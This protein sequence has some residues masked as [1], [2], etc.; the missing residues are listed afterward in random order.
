MTKRS[1]FYRRRPNTET[2]RKKRWNI[3]R[4][5]GGALKRTCMVLGAIMLVWI[6][7]S[8]TI[9]TLM[10]SGA[11]KA[12]LPDE[13][14]VVLKL[15]R[16]LVEKA[17]SPTLFDLF[18]YRQPNLHDVIAK[19]DDAAQDRRVKGFVLSL[20]SG[21]LSLTQIQELRAAIERF[22][23][24][25]KFTK[26]HTPSFTDYGQGM[27]L[28]YLASAFE[29]V[30]MQ[31]VGMLGLTGISLEMPYARE[32]LDKLGA[33]PEFL[34]REEY[35]SAMENFAAS[36]M[37][38]ASRENY[39]A[40]VN[41][42]ADQ[43]VG[44]IARDRKLSKSVVKSYVDLGLL[45]G[46]EALKAK[47][48]DR[49]DYADVMIDDMDEFVTGDRDSDA[50]MYVPLEQYH[51]T[52]LRKKGQDSVAVIQAVG[53]IMPGTSRDVSGA[54]AD[55]IAA[56]LYEAAEDDSIKAVLLRVDSPGGSPS[57]SETIRRAVLNVQDEG[58]QVVVSMG[59][60]A[61]S[62][63]YWIA[64]PADAIYASPATLTG[65][66]G[67]V[68]GKVSLG[69]LW[70]KLG[71]NWQSIR[72]GDNAGMFSMNEPLDA[73]GRARMNAL[74]DQTYDQFLTRVAEGRGMT[75]EEA[76]VVAKGRAWTGAQAK[77][78][79]LVDALGGQADALDYLARELG[80]TNR[81]D[82][83]VIELP[84]RKRPLEQLIELMETQVS[85]GQWFN[86]ARARL[87]TWSGLS[88]GVQAVEP[89]GLFQ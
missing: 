41:D 62:G 10:G 50:D 59:S 60:V 54:A 13:M 31:P 56:A 61:A 85:M 18:P 76:R 78:R 69:G 20:K 81:T 5:M 3:G 7:L 9:V 14:V 29:E 28:Y 1:L 25:G 86:G 49:L 6:V 83:R 44:T 79:G 34:Q 42:Y 32:A 88:S 87:A 24:T 64:A 38:P 33:R 71:I 27:G 66:I 51:R 15:D 17:G 73:K 74:I 2:I 37:S 82:L 68:M 80:H 23:A 48:I 65:S 72:Y 16:G 8:A 26:F 12:P 19:I 22:R 63:G 55:D 40:I 52:A 75:K 58:K 11:R 39:K 89:L 45:S 36:E 57:A 35:K 67:V 47:L 4:I 77:E 84:R 21:G 43:M 46:E 30:W 70:E 53:A